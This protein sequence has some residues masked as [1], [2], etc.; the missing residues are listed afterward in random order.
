MSK[1]LKIT[2]AMNVVSSSGLSFNVGLSDREA[3]GRKVMLKLFLSG[4]TCNLKS[5]ER[6]YMCS[7]CRGLKA[8]GGPRPLE[9]RLRL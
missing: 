6:P 7:C 9:G 5:M 2:V 8:F 1:W 4:V 3:W